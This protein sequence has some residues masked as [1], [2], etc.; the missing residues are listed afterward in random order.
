MLQTAGRQCVKNR[1]AGYETDGTE[2]SA[3]PSSSHA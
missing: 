2:Y 3:R 1:A